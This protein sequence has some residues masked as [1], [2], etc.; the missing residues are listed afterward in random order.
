MNGQI[1]P[2]RTRLDYDQAM[3]RIDEL[4]GTAP[5]TPEGDELDVLLTL[6]DAYEEEHHTIPEA[7]PLEVIKFVMD[8]KGLR[9]KDLAP[10]FGSASRVGEVLNGKRPLTLE[11]IRGLK[12]HLDIP[13]DLLVGDEPLPDEDDDYNEYPVR[14]I[15]ERFGALMKNLNP[16]DQA[17]EIV[18]QLRELAGLDHVRIAAAFRSGK[19]LNITANP[20]ALKAWVLT[21]AAEARRR[22]SEIEDRDFNP[23]RLPDDFLKSVAKLSALERGPLRAQEYLHRFGITLVVVRL[24]KKS[25]VDGAVFYLD[26]HPVVALSLRYDR[27]DYFWFTLLHELAHLTEGHIAPES[28][29]IIEDLELPETDGMETSANKKASDAVIPPEYISHK[30]FKPRATVADIHDLAWQ[31]GIHEALVAGRVRYETGNWRRF[32]QL[33]GH[34]AVRKLFSHEK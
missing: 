1:K 33:V 30:V 2:I 10:Y 8:Q 15:K 21:A 20:Y 32:S 3:N 13:A 14:E 7:D 34:G 24:Y 12:K 6:V 17:E 23:A 19:R 4:W 29:P 26:S 28:E 9:N 18:R 25:K 16:R 31:L 11:A 22:I 5:D 27:L